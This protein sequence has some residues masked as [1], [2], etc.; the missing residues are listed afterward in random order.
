MTFDQILLWMPAF[1]IAA[2]VADKCAGGRF[3]LG[4]KMDEAF[5][6]MG[7]LAV[8]VTGIVVLAPVLAAWLRPLEPLL[9][10]LGIDPAMMASLIANDMGGYS[11]ARSLEISEEMGLMAGCI[12]SS[13]LGCTLVFSIP[14]GAGIIDKKDRPYFFQGVLYGLFTIP[15][16]SVVGG[17]AAGFTAGAVLYNNIPIVLFS[18]A[19]AAAFARWPEKTRRGLEGFC[20]VVA[21][22]SLAGIFIGAFRQLTGVVIPGFA[23]AASVMEGF[24]ITASIVLILMGML[25]LLELLQRALRVPLRRLGELLCMDETS[26]CGMLMTMAN[27]I[28]VYHCYHRMSARGKIVNAA[29][30]VPTTAVLGDH[31]GF[32][33]GVAPE[34]AGPMIIG[35]CTAGILAL[36]IAWVLSP[37]G[38]RPDERE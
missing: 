23:G 10:T 16:G 18:G 1:G 9:C 28:P 19:L 27:S 6:A 24:S 37:T 4:K 26:I 21:S 15:V 13:M 2:A 3:G 33:A 17:L 35:K 20:R 8:S 29:W 31:L 32:T 22:V 25:P 5:E 7:P 14:V 12:T 34:M 30:L 11:L 36:V 38:P